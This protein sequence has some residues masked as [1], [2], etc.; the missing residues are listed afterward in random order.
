VWRLDPQAERWLGAAP[1]VPV[2][3]MEQ[4]GSS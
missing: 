3:G 4:A 1:L 2:A